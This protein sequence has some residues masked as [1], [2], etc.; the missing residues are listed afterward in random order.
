MSKHL[1]PGIC[2][3]KANSFM[4]FAVGIC[5]LVFSP[6]VFSQEKSPDELL[7]KISDDV[8]QLNEITINTSLGTVEIPCKINMSEGLIEVVMCRKEGKIHESLLVTNVSPLEFQTALLLLGLDPVNEVPDDP[9][10]INKNDQFSS[11]ETEGDVVKIYL[12]FESDEETIKQPLE[13]FIF[14]ESIKQNLK[15]STW[16]FRGAATHMSGH[17][18]IDPDVTMIATYHDPV[19]M[20]ELN[21]QSKFNDELFYVNKGAKLTVGKN[22]TLIIEK[23]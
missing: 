3:S 22:V 4:V 19:A 2:G 7:K 11:I 23:L 18:M 6:L 17:V 8:Y 20:M 14:D 16:L 1:F 12:A 10:K 5:M 21:A 13:S 9:S 15:S